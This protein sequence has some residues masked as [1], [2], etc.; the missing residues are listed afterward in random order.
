MNHIAYSGPGGACRLDDRSVLRAQ[1]A[2]AA[3]FL[4]G[5]LSNDV[6]R[7]DA[8]HARLGA[9]CSAQGRMLA[10]F[11][12]ARQGGETLWLSCQSDVLPAALKRLSMFVMR[13]QARLDD[14]TAELA[15]LG[16]VG[17]DALA[18]LG[19]QA[20]APWGKLDL[21][22]GAMLIGLP[23]AAGVARALW[24]GPVA[25]AGLVLAGLPALE[26][27]H[28]RWLEVASGVA[29]VVAATSGQFVPQMLNYELVGGV[30]FKKGCYPGQEVVARS[31]YLG[32]LKRRAF[33]LAGDSVMQPGQDVVWSGDPG[34]PAGV[35]ALSAPQP[36]GGHLAL[37]E[38]KIAVTGSGTLHLGSA[39][40]P[41]LSTR[42]LPYALPHEQAT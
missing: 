13:A 2:D 19:A 33:L 35:V 3:T 41:L 4:H 14:A 11:I 22:D 31:Q 42:P 36:D 1:G 37:A 27:A 7:L 38:L 18:H 30:D 26:P 9:Y 15:T 16:I 6:S 32:K 34:Q 39:D 23:D 28:W 5:Q 17:A 25:R 29:P 10:S 40:G 12:Y 24:L 8:S 20:L 21:E